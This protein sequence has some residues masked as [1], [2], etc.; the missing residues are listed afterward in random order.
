MTAHLRDKDYLEK[1]RKL[2]EMFPDLF[3]HVAP[4]K[5]EKT[6]KEKPQKYRGELHD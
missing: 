4:K 1:M 5:Q 3:K 2:R 6:D